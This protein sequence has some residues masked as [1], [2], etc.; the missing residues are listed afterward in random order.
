MDSFRFIAIT[1]VLLYHF[2]YRWSVPS[3]GG[4][5]CPYGQYFGNIF[6]LG[7]LGPHFF[8]IISGFVITLTL[9][10]TKTPGAFAKARFL[11]LFPALLLCTLLTFLIGIA[12]DNDAIFPAAF[13]IRNF[14]PS[15]TLVSPS[16][17]NLLNIHGLGW[18]NGSYWSL[19]TELQFYALSGLVYFLNKK[20]YLRNMLW[21]TLGLCCTRSI[22]G[23][24]TVAEA[25]NITFFIPLFM[26]GILFYQLYQIRHGKPASVIRLSKQPLI[27]TLLLFLYL[28]AYSPDYQTVIAY[29]CMIVLFLLMI[30]RKSF[31]FFLDNRFLVRIGVISY[32][33]YL[34]HENVG[35]LLIHT[36]GGYL[37][38][39]SPLSP[40][41]VTGLIWL[42]SEYSYRLYEQPLSRLFSYLSRKQKPPSP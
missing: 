14:L 39:Y 7:S 40:F 8:F 19:W 28:S 2:T 18:I 25:F 22:P 9:E 34:I 1:G 21:L 11:R 27:L 31:L 33:I 42:F 32:T 26:M 24:K 23:L 17:W 35:I 12:L 4:R 29:A 38:K 3:T 41:I 6:R 37:G 36:Y 15:L 13:P 16:V 30:Y 10:K 5:V 20:R